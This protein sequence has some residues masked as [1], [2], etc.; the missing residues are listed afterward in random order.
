V[1]VADAFVASLLDAA[2]ANID[3]AVAGD[4]RLRE[5]FARFAGGAPVRFATLRALGIARP[6]P[7]KVLRAAAGG[8]LGPRGAPLRMLVPANAA[9]ALALRFVL[10]EA[11]STAVLR[12]LLEGA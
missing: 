1:P 3:D 11:A 6:T 12:D 2:I 8:P 9:T 4:A 10:E 7:D 5:L